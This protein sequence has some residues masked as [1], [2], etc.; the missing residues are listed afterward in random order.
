VG[1]FALYP[2]SEDTAPSLRNRELT[3][4]LMASSADPA[5][6]KDLLRGKKYLE[7][8]RYTWS[9]QR[10]TEFLIVNLLCVFE[11]VDSHKPRDG[12]QDIHQ[13]SARQHCR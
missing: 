4:I 13:H 3:L 5:V 8:V 12:E 11:R 7:K 9:G 2:D 1:S 10:V 6:F